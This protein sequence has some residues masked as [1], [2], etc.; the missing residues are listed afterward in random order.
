MSEQEKNK[1]KPA[2]TN[3]DKASDKAAQ[4]IAFYD[5]LKEELE[6]NAEWPTQ[7]MYKFIMPNKEEN[8]EKVKNRFKDKDIDY[9]QN[10]SKTGKYVSITVITEEKN[11]DAVISQ[12]KSME[13][14]EGLVAL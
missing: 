9:K 6:K 14:I 12:Y 10:F 8:I 4:K 3:E 7:Y 11:P 13:D 2:Q 5:R 1:N